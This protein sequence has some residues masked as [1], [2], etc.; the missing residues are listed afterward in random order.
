MKTY[1]LQVGMRYLGHVKGNGIQDAI[2]SVDTEDKPIRVHAKKIFFEGQDI[3]IR[4][5]LKKGG[6]LRGQK[7]SE[8]LKNA[9]RT[10]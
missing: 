6:D 7:L 10:P 1:T 2:N 3:I 9:S 5:S 4:P 8:A